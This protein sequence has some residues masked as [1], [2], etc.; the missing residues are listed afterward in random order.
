MCTSCRIMSLEMNNGTNVISPTL[1]RCSLVRLCGFAS[2]T[3]RRSSTSRGAAIVLLLCV[4]S[5]FI[6]ASE[7]SCAYKRN[8]SV[9]GEGDSVGLCVCVC[10]CEGG[11]GGGGA[12]LERITVVKF[13]WKTGLIFRDTSTN[14]DVSNV[15]K[16][17]FSTE[18]ISTVR[19]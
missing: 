18:G 1:P 8:R 3:F 12:K 6:C 16:V 2:W 4:S 10:V 9:S 14:E 13:S 7:A 11:G 17:T 5:D 15:T 19:H